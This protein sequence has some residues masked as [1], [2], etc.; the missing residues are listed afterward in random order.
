MLYDALRIRCRLGDA[1]GI[2]AALERFSVASQDTDPIERRASLPRPPRCASERA[3]AYRCRTQG[4]GRSAAGAACRR[5]SASDHFSAPG[6]RAAQ[7]SLDDALMDAAALA[8]A[9]D[10]AAFLDLDELVGYQAVG[11]TVDLVGKFSGG[12]LDQAVDAA[13][14]LVK[15]VANVAHAVVRAD[16]D[17]L[18]MRPRRAGR[19]QARDMLCVSR[20]VGMWLGSSQSL[21][22]G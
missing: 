9:A 5:R 15:P 8:R 19:R 1:P 10:S 12:C 13:R 2:C 21:G 20:Y 14:C 11:L 16:L 6:A 22:S 7:R 3:R 17:V 4:A 18:L